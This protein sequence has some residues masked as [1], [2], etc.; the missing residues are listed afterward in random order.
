M[1]DKEFSYLGKSAELEAILVELQ[2]PDTSLE[3]A[4]ALHKKGQE[5]LAELEDFLK[6][7][8]VEV[9]KRTARE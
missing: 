1:A 2:Q 8:E 5:I 6:T 7:A 3:D 9:K 4:L